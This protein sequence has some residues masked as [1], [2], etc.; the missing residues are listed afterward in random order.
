MTLTQ[1]RAFVAVADAGS[2]RAAAERLVVTQP[3]VSAAVGALQRSL[4]SDL[5]EPHGRGLRLTEAGQVFAGY[6]RRVLGLLE[7]AET[8]ASG[9]AD[10]TRGN[11]RIAA[12]TTASEHVLP[13]SL[14]SFLDDYPHVGLRLEVGNREQV[15]SLLL[16]HEVDIALAGRPPADADVR[17]RAVRPNELVVVAAPGRA[18]T[19][20]VS[21]AQLESKTWL[22]REAGSGTRAALQRSM[23]AAGIDPPVLTL[24]SN[25]AVVAAATAGLGFGLV[26]R[27]AVDREVASGELRV[28]DVEGTPI[29][30]PW[31][32]VTHL[33]TTPTAEL[34]VA[35][36]TDR[37]R[38]H[39]PPRFDASPGR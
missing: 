18:P 28:V 17:T 36:L 9:G 29:E 31:H 4:G 34:F 33:D 14:A 32:A 24:G 35:H 37:A 7:E 5:V 20:R 8:A 21:L 30:R 12:V 3:A 6:A 11:L 27:D 38:P 1:L 2:V 15:W 10:P 39:P 13:R 26:S 19:G 23:D 25:G 16:Q 22:L